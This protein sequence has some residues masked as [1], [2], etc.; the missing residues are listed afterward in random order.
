VFC[1][2]VGWRKPARTIFESAIKALGTQPGDCL[3]VGDDP[4]WDF[5]GARSAGMEAVLIDRT[6]EHPAGMS[7]IGG[8][9]GLWQKIRLS[10]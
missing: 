9:Q 3:F 8:L 6:G 1:R 10:D 2:D 5:R 7:V 4:R